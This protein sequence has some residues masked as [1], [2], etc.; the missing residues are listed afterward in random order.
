MSLYNSSYGSSERGGQQGPRS[1]RMPYSPVSG[2]AEPVRKTF[3]QSV[4]EFDDIDNMSDM[5]LEKTSRPTESQSRV[6]ARDH[7]TEDKNEGSLYGRRGIRTYSYDEQAFAVTPST[8]GVLRRQEFNGRGYERQTPGYDSGG[9]SI[10]LASDDRSQLS[11][12][13][14]SASTLELSQETEYATRHLTPAT[15]RASQQSSDST[16]R[17]R[18]SSENLSEPGNDATATRAL[19][20]ND[21]TM[22]ETPAFKPPVH[23]IQGSTVSSRWKR[24]GRLGL[25]KPKRND[26]SLPSEESM[27]DG[28]RESMDFGSSSPPKSHEFLDGSSSSIDHKPPSSRRVQSPPRSYLSGYGSID[29]ESSQRHS[30]ASMDELVPEFESTFH[31][32]RSRYSKSPPDAHPGPAIAGRMPYESSAQNVAM[33]ISDVSMNSNPRSRPHSPDIDNATKAPTS[34]GSLSRTSLNENLGSNGKRVSGQ[35]QAEGGDAKEYASSDLVR[36]LALSPLLGRTRPLGSSVGS[37]SSE[38]LGQRA[39]LGTSPNGQN[40]RDSPHLQGHGLAR[41]NT[42]SSLEKRSSAYGDSAMQATS[43]FQQYEMRRKETSPQYRSPRE[44]QRAMGSLV[45][46]AD[47]SMGSADASRIEEAEQSRLDPYAPSEPKPSSRRLNSTSSSMRMPDKPAAPAYDRRPEHH[48]VNS[49]SPRQSARRV[50]AAADNNFE[51]LR[52][53]SSS[54][55]TD[56]NVPNGVH[57]GGK[58]TNM[59]VEDRDRSPYLSPAVVAENLALQ[60]R[61]ME[62]VSQVAQQ[63]KPAYSQPVLIPPQ[64][65]TQPQLQTSSQPKATAQT[66]P[67]DQQ[68]AVQG[69]FATDPKR[70]LVVNGRSYQKICVFGR[71]GSSKVLK[72]MSPKYEVY[73]IKRVSFARADEQAIKGYINEITLLRKFVGN[74]YI[75]QL[76]DN[77]INKERGLINM[78]MEFGETDLANVL[79]RQGDRPLGMNTIRLYWEQMLKAVQVIHDERVVHAD[80][81]PANYLLVRG[82]LKLIDFGIAKSISND[83][84]NIHRDSQ[85]GTVNYMS[86]EAIK[87][88]NTEGGAR[89]MKLGRASDI[90]SLGVILY[91]MCY[92]RTPFAQLALFQ[93]LASIPDPSFV[94][95]Y[96]RFMAGCLQVGKENDPNADASMTCPDGSAKAEVPSDL[97]QV[98]KGCLQRDPSKRMTIPELLVDPLLCPISLEHALSSATSQL[99]TLLKRTPQVLDKWDVS[100]S[101]NELVLSSLIRALHLQ[102][103]NK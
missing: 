51:E 103:Q 5:D 75:I 6:G 68:Q 92:G 94:I 32:A 72:V 29:A 2:K 33:D 93:K 57:G 44:R 71:G 91:Q 3:K 83:T 16:A 31:T 85:V 46:S 98:M 101:Q 82:S 99:L 59:Q 73:A 40:K 49:V 21:Y 18:F 66:T 56:E 17:V 102:E 37:A 53:G 88:T 36:R 27:H 45:R 9:H 97:L 52:R 61:Y 23:P 63:K 50:A 100:A 43:R 28:D 41:A 20:S 15:Y 58:S 64:Q 79:K 76:Y 74:P 35:R 67:Q 14:K 54:A 42:A 7:A 60:A 77:E 65:A 8:E 1:S 87:E 12:E 96:P 80:L 89:L 34:A 26:P 84:T 11:P 4:D 90:W 62:A 38:S 69:G 95:P 19:A 30:F 39:E 13:Y 48:R 55:V 70:T 22:A 78:V 25:A 81:K 10:L 86:P 47:T 24:R